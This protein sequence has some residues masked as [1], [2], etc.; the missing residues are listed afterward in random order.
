MKNEYTKSGQAMQRQTAQR[1]G[2]GDA[3][4]VHKSFLDA[5]LPALTK[6]V[7]QG[8]RP[9]ALIRFC[10]LDL[11]QSDRLRACTPQSIYLGL[12][13]CAVTGL[14][15]SEEHTSELQSQR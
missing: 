11:Q 3:I 12:L 1:S 7:R 14:E 5:R 2:P 8:L 6:W 13:A 10:L 9:E 15:R 4:A